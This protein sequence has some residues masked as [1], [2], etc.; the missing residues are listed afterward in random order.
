MKLRLVKIKNFKAIEDI[1]IEFGD[2]ANIICGPNATGKSTILEAIRLVRAMLAPR[3]PN[4]GQHVLTQLQATSPHYP[5]AGILLDAIASDPRLPLVIEA[6]FYLDDDE[7]SRLGTMKHDLA[8]NLLQAQFGNQRGQIDLVPLLSTPQGQQ[9]L[10]AA[11]KQIDQL[12]PAMRT[13]RTC[14]LHLELRP[15]QGFVA[16][17]NFIGAMIISTLERNL[18]F[19]LALMSFFPADRALPPGETNIQLGGQDAAQLLTSHAMTPQ[20]KYNRLKQTIVNS[21]V[22]PYPGNIDIKGTFNRIFEKLLTGRVLE[23]IKVSQVGQI[24]IPVRD[25]RSNRVFDIDGL[26]SGEKG[27]I[28]TLLLMT[29]SVA[30]NGMIFIDEPELH[31]NPALC[32]SLLPF[33]IDECLVPFGRQAII[34]SHSPEIL[35]SAFDDDRCRLFNL[36][37]PRTISPIISGDRDELFVALGALGVSGA[38]PPLI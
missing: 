9:M 38:W 17:P 30:N 16:N 8:I 18:P 14:Q 13:D 25:L 29:T 12:L 7:L 3:S 6:H 4:E 37:G 20:T 26:S 19:N 24:N 35:A 32:R 21:H 31:L 36:I 22:A 2:V 1:Q 28:L 33:V 34:C 5:Q 15:G 23:P 10:G 11:Q 27:L